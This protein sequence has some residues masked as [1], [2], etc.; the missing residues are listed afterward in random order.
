MRHR[1]QVNSLAQLYGVVPTVMNS[2][3]KQVILLVKTDWSCAPDADDLA[4]MLDRLT[5]GSANVPRFREPK[6]RNQPPRVQGHGSRSAAPA[7]PPRPGGVVG[8]DAPALDEQNLGNRML[9]GMG[10]SP[11]TGLGACP[12]AHAM[13]RATGPQL[14]ARIPLSG[15]ATCVTASGRGGSGQARRGPAF[16]CRSRRPSATGV[17]ASAHEQA[18]NVQRVAAVL[19]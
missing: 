5:A 19:G 6:V 10:W 4:A 14:T 7:G 2:G 16:W 17:A 18:R 15:A 12:L 8:S 1:F 9:R 11:G 3:R 13:G